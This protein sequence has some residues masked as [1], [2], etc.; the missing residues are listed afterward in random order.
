MK[1]LV[2]VAETATGYSAYAPDL[3]GC[4]ASGAS[5]AE[6]EQEMRS[7]VEF[8]LEGQRAHGEQPP[9]SHSYATF[10]EVAA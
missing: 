6:V 9:E 2:I 7:A 8:H 4:I 10:V 5:R 3:P 1:V